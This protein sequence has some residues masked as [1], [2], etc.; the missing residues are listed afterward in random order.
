ME[1]GTSI[2][3][4]NIVFET[5][6]LILRKFT[7]SDA[8]LLV[9]LNNNPEVMKYLHEPLLENEVQAL[10]VL[11]TIILPQYKFNLG[12][13]AIHVKTTNEFIGWCGLK[14]LIETHEVDLGYRLMQP[15]WGKGYAFEAATHTVDYGF[16]QLQLPSIVGRAHIENIASLKI[17]EKVGLQ[18]IKDEVVDGCPV[19]T[20]SLSNPNS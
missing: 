12:R 16:N 2:Y 17:L 13:W 19:K 11:N 3:I 10:H 18:F 1:A 4:M 9:Q 15:Y 20:Y 14:Y 8:P 7:E 5:P 6:R